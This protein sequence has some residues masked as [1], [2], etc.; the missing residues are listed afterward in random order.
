MKEGAYEYITKPFYLEQMRA[1]VARAVERSFLVREAEQKEA[2]RQLSITD[3]LTA[4]YNHRYFHEALA[5]GSW[6][7][8]NATRLASHCS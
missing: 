6:P 1:A 3:G 8:R 7:G 5:R 2:Y 4:L